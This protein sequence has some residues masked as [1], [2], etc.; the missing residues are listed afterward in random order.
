MNFMSYTKNISV[1]IP[2]YNTD[3][4]LRDCLDSILSQTLQDFEIICIDDASTDNSIHILKKY[5]EQDSRIHI[6]QFNINEGEASARNAGLSAADGKYIGFVDSDDTIYPDFFEIL[7]NTAEET[8][9]DI[10]KG[11]MKITENGV[12]QLKDLNSVIRRNR[13]YF[14]SQFT[15][16]IYRNSLLRSNNIEFPSGIIRGADRAFLLKVVAV[17]QNL[18]TNDNAVYHYMRR[19]NSSDTAQLT[20]DKIESNI[21]SCKDYIKFVKKLPSIDKHLHARQCYDYMLMFLHDPTRSAEKE[22]ACALCAKA[23]FTLYHECLFQKE[24]KEFLKNQPLFF[25]S[26]V[27]G[28]METLIKYIG[29]SQMQ[30]IRMT[31]ALSKQIREESICT[32]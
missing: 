30:R 3:K 10:V 1:I 31:V 19:D 4:Y 2:V 7:Y 20:L 29:L 13:Y 24:L 26:I 6:I 5:A 15:S 16:A 21:N 14:T 8:Q 12:T 18:V 17:C 27:N 32:P 9:A 22:K 11:T 23:L 25:S 28:D